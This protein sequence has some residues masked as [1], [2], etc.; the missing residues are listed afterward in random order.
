MYWIAAHEKWY[1]SCCREDVLSTKHWMYRV[2]IRIRFFFE[3]FFIVCTYAG[4]DH[5]GE[6]F[7]LAWNLLASGR[8]WLHFFF[9]YSPTQSPFFVRPSIFIP[10][11]CSMST[12]PHSPISFFLPLIIHNQFW[13]SFKKKCWVLPGGNVSCLPLAPLIPS[14]LHS[15]PPSCSKSAQS[16]VRDEYDYTRVGCYFWSSRTD[17]TLQCLN[18]VTSSCSRNQA[19]VR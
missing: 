18:E 11:P 10:L 6:H 5:V 19:K 16:W 13:P 1:C 4:F 15:L 17:T 9:F 12:P 3:Q 14:A 8:I 2:L 7:L